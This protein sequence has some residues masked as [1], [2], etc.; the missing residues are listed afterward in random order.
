M[1]TVHQVY[2][3]ALAIMNEKDEN[4]YLDRV[5][6]LVNTLI[7]QVWTMSEDFETGSRAIWIPVENIEDEILGIDQNL[8]LS[9]M[10]YGLAG[11]LYIDEDSVRAN[12]WWQIYQEGIVDSRRSPVAFDSIVDEYPFMWDDPMQGVW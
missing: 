2:T 8:A 10:P 7:G 9:V 11:L 4:N 12:S 6:P 5:V 3:T 1:A